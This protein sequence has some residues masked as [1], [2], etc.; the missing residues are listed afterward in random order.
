MSD[1]QAWHVSTTTVQR[2]LPAVLR[3]LASA[4]EGE[5]VVLTNSDGD[6]DFIGGTFRLSVDVR[7]TTDNVPMIRRLARVALNEG[8]PPPKG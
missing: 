1:E 7:E 5:R 2:T 6:A 4:I 8:C 3:E